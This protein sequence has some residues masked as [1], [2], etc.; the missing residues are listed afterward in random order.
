MLTHIRLDICLRG[1][2]TV[3]GYSPMHMSGESWPASLVCAREVND[4]A[5][6]G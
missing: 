3:P 5:D 4:E 1:A 6:G 2:D